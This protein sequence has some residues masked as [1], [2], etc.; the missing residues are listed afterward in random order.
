MLFLEVVSCCVEQFTNYNGS[1]FFGNFSSID[2][3]AI[4]QKSLDRALF[5]YTFIHA[6]RS[7]GIRVSFLIVHIRKFCEM[8]QNIVRF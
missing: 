3:L 7:N 1:K 4:L 8:Q 2:F 5:L 6:V